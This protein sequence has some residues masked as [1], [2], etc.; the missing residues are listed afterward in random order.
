M[1]QDDLTQETLDDILT[2]FPEVIEEARRRSTDIELR[3]KVSEYLNNDIPAYFGEQPALYLARHVATP[4]FE[5]LR[6]MHLVEPLGMPIIVTEDTKDKF[7]PHNTLKKTLCKM[8][9][10]L[11]AHLKEGKMIEEFRKISI[12]DFNTANGKSFDS[13]TTKWG[14]PLTAFHTDL[15]RR[16]LRMK[17]VLADDTPWIDRNCRGNLL[18]HYQRFLALFIVHGVLFEDYIIG[19]NEEMQFMREILRP[20]FEKVTTH[21][22]VKP[23]ITFLH[24]TSLE[25]SLFWMSYPR[26]VL[27][28][29]EERM[30]RI[31]ASC[32]P[33]R[34]L[35]T[36][37][38]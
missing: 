20:A 28:I 10:C 24:P 26:E 13:I 33:G 9:I 18:E 37:P 30:A 4:N 16:F 6:F 12:V 21:F 8:P 19:D 22:G 2:P 1:P 11:G 29:V 17:I 14:E 5:T 3:K 32:T 27:D 31:P 38:S 7:V 36:Q 15:L 34:T 35:R 23:L 25:S